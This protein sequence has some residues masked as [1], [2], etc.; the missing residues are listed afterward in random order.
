[1]L[2][3]AAMREIGIRQP[4]CM[5]SF[6]VGIALKADAAGPHT[7]FSAR[8]A[9]SDELRMGNQRLEYAPVEDRRQATT[10]AAFRGAN[11][12]YSHRSEERRV[13]KECRSRWSPNH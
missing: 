7:G 10:R 2:W 6:S 3:R 9:S 11:H 8:G 13:G 1:M 5:T 4:A 12:V